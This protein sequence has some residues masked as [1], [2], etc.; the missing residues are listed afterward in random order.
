MSSTHTR[1]EVQ[2]YLNRMRAALADLPDVEISE[3]MDDAGSHVVEVADELGENFS[4]EALTTRL[5]TPEVYARELRVAAGYPSAAVPA[6]AG[7]PTPVFAA[8]FAFWALVAGTA[9]AFGMGISGGSGFALTLLIGIFVLWAL[10]L[11]HRREELLGH[12]AVLP[13]TAALTHALEQAEQ[14][15]PG[16]TIA[17][18]RSLQPAWWLARAALIAVSGLVIAGFSAIFL[19]TL[20]LAGLALMAGPRAKTD[21]RWLWVSLP[22]AGFAAGI[23]LFILGSVIPHGRYGSQN[24]TSYVPA[25]RSLPTNIY[26]FDKDGK[27]LTDVYLYDESGQPIE[28]S[29]QGCHGYREDNKYPRPKVDYQGQSCVEI[30]GVPFAVAIPTTSTPSSTPSVSSSSVTPP[31]SV[32]SASST[33]VPTSK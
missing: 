22:A 17:Y 19:F 13:E 5:G 4:A 9:A 18:L 32:S 31:S 8:R 24:Q 3:I 6:T 30:G 1:A 27:A 23:V 15:S 21:R 20:A 26:V 2:E 14:G 28:R 7:L 11:L 25:A 10:V 33:T 29:W 12:V 16:K